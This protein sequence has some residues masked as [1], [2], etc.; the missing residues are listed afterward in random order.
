MLDIS[1]DSNILAY[2]IVIRFR[3][4]A[5]VTFNQVHYSV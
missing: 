4:H 5:R 3:W 1:T 2:D